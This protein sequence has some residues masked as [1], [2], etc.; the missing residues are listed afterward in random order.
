[1]VGKGVQSANNFFQSFERVLTWVHTHL[2]TRHYGLFAD[3]VSIFQFFT[4]GHIDAEVKYTSF[5]SQHWTGFSSS[6]EA[7]VASSVQNLFPAIFGK[8]DANADI[9]QKH[10]PP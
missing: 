8:S 2:L 6:S 7:R 3:A 10:Y 9:F 1:M 5:S 4:S